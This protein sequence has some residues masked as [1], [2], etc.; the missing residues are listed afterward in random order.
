MAGLLVTGIYIL[1][2]LQKVLHGP[3]GEA[4]RHHPLPDISVPE[5]LAV[6]PLMLG[7]LIIGIY[8]AVVLNIINTGV[9]RL[10]Q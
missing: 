3:L 8:P 4:W 1:K 5:V 10:F 9:V 7:M 2:A 6:A